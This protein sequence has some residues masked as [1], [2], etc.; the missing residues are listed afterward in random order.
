MRLKERIIWIVVGFLLLANLFVLLSA[1]LKAQ[2]A[3]PS[4]TVALSAGEKGVVYFYDGANLWFSKD[5]GEH[6]RKVK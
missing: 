3:F 6:W 1:P 2:S 5:Y 4:S